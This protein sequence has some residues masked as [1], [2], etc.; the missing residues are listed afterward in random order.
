MQDYTYSAFSILALAL[1][2]IF[3]RDI[4]FRRRIDTAHGRSYRLFLVGVL[5]YY[6]SDA[7]WGIFAGLRWIVPWYVDTLFFF[8]SLVLLVFLWSRFAADYLAFGRTARRVLD[9]CGYALLAFNLAAMAV[10]PFTRC[11]FFFDDQGVYQVGWLRDPAFYL[12]VGYG[13]FTTLLVVA[14]GIRRRDFERRRSAMVVLCGVAMSVAMIM[15]VAWP[16]TPFTS[17]GCL[18]VNCFFQVFV[19]Q[20]ERLAKHTAELERA[21]ERARAAEKA[22]SMFFSIVSHDIRTPL[23][24][25]IG[26]SELLQKGTESEAERNEALKSIRASGKTLLQL[27][28]DVL[29]LAK[30]DAGKMALRPE[31]VILNQLTDEVFSSFWRDASEKGVR[32]VNGTDG[33]PT[34][35]IDGHRFRQILF[36]LIGNAVKFTKTGSVEVRATYSEGVLVVS[37]VDT[38]CGIAPDMVDRV[39]EPFV[40]AIDPSHAADRAAGTGLGLSIC[41]RLVETMGGEIDVQSEMGKGSTFTVRIPGVEVL[42]SGGVGSGGVKSG[43]VESGGVEELT[44]PLTHS[45]TPSLPHSPTHPRPHSPTPDSHHVLVVDDSP[46]NRKVLTAFLKRTGIERIDQAGDGV[47]ALEKL[48]SALKSGD[49]HDFVL[50]DYWMPNMNGLELIERI[51]ADARF[52]SLHVVAV[53]ADTECRKDD[54]SSLFSGILLKPVT[55]DQIAE[56]MGGELD[57]ES[58][59]GKGSTFRARIPGVVATSEKAASEPKPVAVPKRMPKRV[60]VVDDS[61]IN[62]AVL[63]SLLAHAGVG[64]VDQASD[65]GEALSMLGEA[66]KANQAYD[67]VF[68]DLWMPNLNGIELVEKLRADSR[69]RRL[70]VYAV[71]A[72][73]EFLRDDRSRHFT[74]ILLK[75]LSYGKLMEVFA[76]AMR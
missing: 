10:N 30:M 31:P 71:T 62:R 12:M 53:T 38:G 32:L 2:L 63:S 15:Q 19:I 64:S 22:R 18:I 29:D 6:V 58:E 14:N 67:F 36:N 21:L 28:N 16:L 44:H 48:D 73:V 33:V 70:P 23:N 69:F 66:Q 27:V 24:A 74:G 61:P 37:V 41:R 45:L 50:S 35:M 17:L 7:A 34:V 60:L 46:V 52:S 5:A 8:L 49:P 26:Y 39:L 1:H 75:P 11:L 65:G 68:T 9:W 55:Y 3:N 51:R 57:A 72:D 43:G 47:E 54:R 13:M 56:A 76:N 25:I 59:V 42:E 20:D 4:L 40:Q